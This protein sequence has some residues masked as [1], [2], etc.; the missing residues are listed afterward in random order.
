MEKFTP[1][2]K[3]VGIAY[4]QIGQDT[5]SAETAEDMINDNMAFSDVVEV[6][7]YTGMS[8]AKVKGVIG[9]LVKK[10][11]LITEN[12]PERGEEQYMNE[13]FIPEF[14]GYMENQ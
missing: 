6:S 10:G 1:D 13:T 3:K 5:N 7:E 8:K 14:W 12:D 4:L 9:S 2:E 11:V